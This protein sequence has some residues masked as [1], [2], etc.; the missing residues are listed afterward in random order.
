M[1]R[2]RLVCSAPAVPLF[3]LFA[4]AAM[5]PSLFRRSRSLPRRVRGAALI[6]VLVSVL[7]F[8][9]GVL[10]LLG[11]QVV[12]MRNSGDAQLRSRAAMLANEY[13]NQVEARVTTVMRQ[14][15]SSAQN[16]ALHATVTS[17]CDSWKADSLNASNVDKGLPGAT[18]SCNLSMTG[19]LAVVTVNLSWRQASGP[20]PT[21][22]NLSFIKALI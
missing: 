13:F 8:F 17:V 6:E 14:S 16:T 11:F 7:I 22:Y 12:S 20:N 3:N 2:C 1:A 5:K 21:T 4:E 9:I 18:A 19:G 15:S 10:G